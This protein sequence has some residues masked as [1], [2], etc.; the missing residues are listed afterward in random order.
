VAD[1]S[2]FKL[3][4]EETIHWFRVALP[5]AFTDITGLFRNQ[6][7]AQT[8]RRAELT[9]MNDRLLNAFLAGPSTSQPSTPNGPGYA[10]IWP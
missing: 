9:T 7:S 3:P 5:N 10:M 8:K 1:L 6:R 2:S 4:D